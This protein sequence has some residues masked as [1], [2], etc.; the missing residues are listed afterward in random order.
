M[1]P[2]EKLSLLGSWLQ[3]AVAFATALALFVA[4]LRS[5]DKR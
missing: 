3:V 2:Y 5:Q 4:W 1:T